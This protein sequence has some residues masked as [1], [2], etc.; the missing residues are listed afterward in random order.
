MSTLKSL[1]IAGLT[2]GLLA[3]MRA[4]SASERSWVAHMGLV[5][6]VLIAVSPLVLA[7]KA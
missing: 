6:L 7:D 1:L 5:M 2:L 4:R 3:L